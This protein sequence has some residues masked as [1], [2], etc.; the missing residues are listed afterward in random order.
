MGWVGVCMCGCVWWWWGGDNILSY[1]LKCVLIICLWTFFTILTLLKKNKANQFNI[2]KKC[3]RT[4]LVSVLLLRAYPW[5]RAYPWNLASRVPCFATLAHSN[6]VLAL[7][8]KLCRDSICSM[9]NLINTDSA[10][11]CVLQFDTL[12]LF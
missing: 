12:Y 1:I 6:R 7:E 4:I 8:H 2:R 10:E 9:V 3:L 5:D 11:I